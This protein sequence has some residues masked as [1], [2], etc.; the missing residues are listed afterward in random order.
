[1]SAGYS[2]GGLWAS[3]R[4][5]ARGKSRYEQSEE[6]GNDVFD[7]IVNFAS[8]FVHDT[9]NRSISQVSTSAEF[10]LPLRRQAE[11]AKDFGGGKRELAGPLARINGTLTP[12]EPGDALL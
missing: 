9:R 4:G 12:R 2:R 8:A 3:F 11:R 10:Q 7:V 5:E 1:M 6:V